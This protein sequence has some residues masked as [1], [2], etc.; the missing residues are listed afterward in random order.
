[1]SS[2]SRSQFCFSTI[3]Q[4]QNGRRAACVQCFGPPSMAGYG[5]DRSS[6]QPD[7]VR[8]H[9]THNCAA[10]DRQK[11]QSEL[12]GQLVG[13][14]CDGWTSPTGPMIARSVFF[15]CIP[16]P[17]LQGDPCWEFALLIKGRRRLSWLLVQCVTRMSGGVMPSADL[18]PDG[19]PMKDQDVKMKIGRMSWRSI[20]IIR[21]KSW[22]W[23]P[24]KV[25]KEDKRDP[26]RMRKN[27]LHDLPFGLLVLSP[28]HTDFIGNK[29]TCKA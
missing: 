25:K 29:G 11:W 26:K 16:H 12:C 19:R 5:A 4:V 15:S 27:W 13:L 24:S 14:R 1:M 7:H 28:Y 22:S 23:W 2:I 17:S 20:T 9:P 3:P 10:E 18:Q 21:K 6:R 8:I